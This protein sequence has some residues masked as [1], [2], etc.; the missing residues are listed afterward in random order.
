LPYGPRVALETPAGLRATFTSVDDGNLALHVGDHPARVAAARR[1]LEL[2]LGLDGPLQFMDQVHSAEVHVVPP[3]GA[4]GQPGP[5]AG[6]GPVADALVSPDASRPLAVLV[7][8]CLP[9]V[10]AARTADG[11]ATAVAHAGRRGLLDGILQRTVDALMDCGSLSIEAW[12]GPSICG[13]CYEVPEDMAAEAESRLPGIRSRTS[14][15]TDSLDLP[16]AA[17][18]V[19]AAAGV[20][21]HPSGTCTREE[22]GYYSYRRD[23]S[24]GRFAGIVWSNPTPHHA[25]EGQ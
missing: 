9:V 19:L 25:T 23:P 17:A 10:F 3:R 6:R 12:I 24:C 2:R 4:A 22:D 16:G 11:A 8:D 21:V 1:A 13:R 7:A 15:N 18:R 14:W 20:R 5:A